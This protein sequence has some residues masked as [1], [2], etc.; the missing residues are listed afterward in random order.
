MVDTPTGSGKSLIAVAAHFAA[1]AD[2][3]RSFYTAPIKALVSEKFFDPGSHVRGRRGR[4]ADRRRVDQ[5]RCPDHL[6]HGRDPGQPRAAR[7]PLRGRRSGRHGRVPLLR[8]SR[9]GLG[10]AGPATRAPRRSVRPDV[11]HARR[12]E[13]VHRHVLDRTDRPVAVIRSATRPIPSS[14]SSG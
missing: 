3:R 12:C 4:H 6:L 7:G 14:T 9:S 2:R 10:V 1:L 5:P 8:R 11:R 13:P